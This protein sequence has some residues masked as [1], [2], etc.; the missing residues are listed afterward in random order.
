MH[1]IIRMEKEWTGGKVLFGKCLRLGAN[2]LWGVANHE[3]VWF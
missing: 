3:H 1:R 2:D